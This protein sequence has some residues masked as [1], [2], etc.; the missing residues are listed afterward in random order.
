[1]LLAADVGGTRTRLGWYEAGGD[2]P[3]ARL[4]REYATTDFAS[5]EEVVPHFLAETGRSAPD[6]FCAG[7]AGPVRGSVARLVNAPWT[8]DLDAVR[9][10]LGDC[11]ALLL[12]DLEALASA[13]PVLEPDELATLQ[14]GVAVPS[15]NAAVIHHYLYG[16]YRRP[17]GTLETRRS[18]WTDVLLNEGGRWS[19]IADH[20]GRDDLP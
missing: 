11:P 1:M 16:Y 20:G 12:N 4:V 9:A 3:A 10:R 15:G 6:A 7:V 8:A 17:D 5:L 14:E 18:R 2:R 19:W 13:I